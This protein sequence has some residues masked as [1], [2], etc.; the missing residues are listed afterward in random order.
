MEISQ[1]LK[2]RYC[3]IELLQKTEFKSIFENNTNILE[4]M[5]KGTYIVFNKNYTLGPYIQHPIPKPFKAQI[6]NSQYPHFHL[7]NLD[8]YIKKID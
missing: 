6:I 7:L 1:K 2:F 8:E 5:D 4:F 3:L